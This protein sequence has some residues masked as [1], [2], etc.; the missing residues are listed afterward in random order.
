MSGSE[1]T[2]PLPP[3]STLGEGLALKEIQS[4]SLETKT[5]TLMSLVLKLDW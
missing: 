5:G 4:S 3:C 2:R 1:P